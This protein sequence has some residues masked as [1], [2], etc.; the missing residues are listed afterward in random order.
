MP[1]KWPTTAN[2]NAVPARVA[3]VDEVVM[4]TPPGKGGISPYVLAAA[5][6]VGGRLTRK[7]DSAVGMQPR[8][9]PE[10]ASLQLDVSPR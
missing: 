5:K 1:K 8:D 7:E 6:V 2:S 3:G 9:R 4:V 10:L